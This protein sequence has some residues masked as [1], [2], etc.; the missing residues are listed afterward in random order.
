MNPR[1][2]LWWKRLPAL[3]EIPAPDPERARRRIALMECNIMLPLKVFVIG[4]IL[5]SFSN[6]PWTGSPS[7]SGVVVETVEKVFWFYIV[8]SALLALPLLAVR[9]LPLAVGQW[10][11]VTNSLVDALLLAAMTLLT[12]GLD[13]ILFWLFIGLILRNAV[14]VPPG[15][16]QLILNF[17]VSLCFALAV[18]LDLSI[19]NSGDDATQRIFDPALREDWGEPFILRL[20]VLWLM[21]LCCSGVELLLE[22]QRLALE[23]AAE[24]AAAENQLHSAGRMAA[25]FAHQIKNPLAIINNATHSIQRSLREKRAV[26]PE[27]IEIIQEEVARVDQVITQ[28]VGYAKLNEERVEKLNVV[29]N[30]EAAL[31]QV[32]PPALPSGIKL[33]KVYASNIPPLLMQRGHLREILV[34]LLTNAREALGEQGT[35]TVTA[36]FAR[37]QAVEISVADTGP[38][39]PPERLAQVFEAYFTT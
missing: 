28:I 11:A 32:F 5:Y 25:E 18:G 35:L 12:G 10:V 2:E 14:S 19:A 38:G 26:A 8:A 29:K 6:S 16:S 7:E 24:F 27:H 39:I 31:A 3:F 23:E 17:L 37:D 33:K 1:R 15:I 22:R 36:D 21:T 4:L 9:Q 13:S 20:V 30:I 34:N